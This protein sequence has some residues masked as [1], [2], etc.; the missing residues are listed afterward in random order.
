[1][2]IDLVFLCV[3]IP[4]VLIA[5]ISKGGFGGGASFVATPILALVMDPG[6]SLGVM[7]PLLIL[8]DVAGLRAY[9]GKW[10]RP[11]ALRL[12]AGGVPGIAL[13][14]MIYTYTDP[15]VFRFLIG[16]IS[17]A[18]VVFQLGLLR[19]WWAVRRAPLSGGVGLGCGVASGFTSFVAHAGGPT[20][21][22]Y[23]L[24]QGL[25]KVQFQATTVVVFSVLNLIKAG[26]YG[27]LGLFSA[28]TFRL[29]LVLA[30]VALA[31]VLIGVKANRI[32]PE[33]AFFGLTYGLLCLAGIK[34]IYDALT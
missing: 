18:F 8:M 27:P 28:E 9:W 19:G 25:T 13:A 15:D 23:L 1:M 12:I 14:A 16:A 11:A 4:G 26:I 30:P 17:I 7:L 21:L 29:V 34:L 5:G 32:V 10:S 22:I 33:R 31:G 2:T 20:A 6:L 3:A 24:S